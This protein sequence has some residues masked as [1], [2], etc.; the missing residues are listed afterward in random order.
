MSSVS[1]LIELIKK[2]KYE[3]DKEH[4]DGISSDAKDL[5]KHC[6]D[7]NPKTRYIPSDAL[8]HNWIKNVNPKKNCL[9]N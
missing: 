6:M 5:V 8:M 2:G 7:V 4:W 1:E 9:K 3:F